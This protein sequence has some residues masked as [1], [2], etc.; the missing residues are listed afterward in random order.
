VKGRCQLVVLEP[1]GCLMIV[2]VTFSFCNSGR[3]AA[4][5]AN[6]VYSLHLFAA[7]LLLTVCLFGLPASRAC[8]VMQGVR[9]ALINALLLEGIWFRMWPLSGV[10]IV[11]FQCWGICAGSATGAAPGKAAQILGGTGVAVCARNQLDLD[12][13]GGIH[14]CGSLYTA[15]LCYEACG[16]RTEGRMT[17]L[18]LLAVLQFLLCHGHNKWLQHVHTLNVMLCRIRLGCPG[19]AAA[20]GLPHDVRISCLACVW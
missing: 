20:W 19:C 4:S 15:R 11:V 18:L 3:W 5:N 16:I 8:S 1:R 13:S 2:S 6:A 12:N 17:C 10:G 7:E 14:I 9:S